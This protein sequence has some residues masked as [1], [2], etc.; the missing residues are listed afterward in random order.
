MGL[1]NLAADEKHERQKD[2]VTGQPNIENA[3][4]IGLVL[5]RSC[6]RPYPRLRSACRDRGWRLTAGP[7][8]ATPGS[9]QAPERR[10]PAHH[11]HPREPPER[12]SPRRDKPIGF[13]TDGG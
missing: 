13:G 9:T 1:T 3:L 6:R 5:T 2:A 10:S 4:Q 11:N 8:V 7:G 12:A